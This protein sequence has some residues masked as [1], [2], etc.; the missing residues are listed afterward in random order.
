MLYMILIR[1]S[2]LSEQE[3]FPSLKLQK[4][5]DDYNEALEKAGVKVMAKGLKPTQNAIRFNYDENSKISSA[6]NGPFDPKESISG[7]FLFD[8]QSYEEAIEWAQKCPDPI[9]EGSG[10]IELRE[11][12]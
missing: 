11:L 9:G 4:A 1:A 2:V 6:L 7:F 5:M 8:V 10:S 3:K 12:Y